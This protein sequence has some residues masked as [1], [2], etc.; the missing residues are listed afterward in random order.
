MRKSRGTTAIGRAI[1][2]LGG[3]TK[4]PKKIGVSYQTLH[5]WHVRGAVRDIA[6]A[7]KISRLTGIPLEEFA[8]DA[9]AESN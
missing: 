3:A 8:K 9:E 1:D 5:A 4:A 7:A 6:Q 2:K